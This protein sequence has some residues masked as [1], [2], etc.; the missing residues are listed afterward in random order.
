MC[1]GMFQHVCLEQDNLGQKFEDAIDILRQHS[2]EDLQPSS[3][4]DQKCY[5]PLHD[6]YPQIR[7]YS[8][9]FGLPAISPTEEFGHNWR[10]VIDNAA[11]FEGN[12]YPSLQD[13]TESTLTPPVLCQQKRG[14]GQRDP[15]HNEQQ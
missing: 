5:Q 3:D 10:T 14:K 13:I 2:M 6:H 15:Q 1:S 7:G 12:I 8:N 9:C 11:V 4:K